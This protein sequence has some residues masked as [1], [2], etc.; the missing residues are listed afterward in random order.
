MTELHNSVCSPQNQNES[1]CNN[2]RLFTILLDKR[3]GKK[4]SKNLK[5]V[6]PVLV[7]HP[8]IYLNKLCRRQSNSLSLFHWHLCIPADENPS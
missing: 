5:E 2:A 6:V 3:K 8:S 7:S 4:A 1:Y